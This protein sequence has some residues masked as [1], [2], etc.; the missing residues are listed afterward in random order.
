MLVKLP[1]PKTIPQQYLVA[2]ELEQYLGNPL[3]PDHEFSF[4]KIVEFDEQE[5]YPHQAHQ[6]LD[7][8]NLN[9]YH[10][11]VAYGGKLK[12]YEEFFALLRTVAR[13][14][15]TTAISYGNTFL[16]AVPIWVGGT[17]QQKNQ[18]AKIIKNRGKVSLAFH[19]K[20]HGSDFL[21]TDVQAIK[22]EDGYR[23]DGEK[24]LFGNAT[25]GS[26][27]TVFAKTDVNGG[28][29]GFSLF[30]LEKQA[31]DRSSYSYLSKCKTLGIRGADCSGIRFH[32]CL[33][34][35]ESLIS[36]QGS[37]L[38]LSLK[39]FQ[40][41]RTVI[42][43][44]ALGSADTALRTTISFALSRK[45]YGDS[46]FAI[47]HTQ[48]LLVDAFLDILICECVAIATSRAVHAAT[49]QMRLWSAVVK[50]FVPTTIE[51]VIHNL[52][53]VMGA[54]YYLRE[55]HHGGIFQKIV[56][57][58]AVVSMFHAGTY[59]NLSTIGAALQFQPTV[60]IDAQRYAEIESSL[61]SIFALDQ[62][63]PAFEPER[64]ELFS[65]KRNDIL[66]GMVVA[67]NQLQSLQMKSE[68]NLEV[69]TTLLSQANTILSEISTQQTVFK[70]MKRR[71]GR[72]LE[73]SPELFE[74]A[75]KH[76]AVHTAAACLYMWLYNRKQLGEFFA[77]GEWL[78]LCLHKL[79]GLL[80]HS[81][82]PLPTSYRENVATELQKLYEQNQLFS[83]V[84]LK[85]APSKA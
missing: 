13:R 60:D 8:W 41:T 50:Y 78:V 65:R 63:L 46:I 67:I 47:P 34:P 68:V 39:A 56:R 30:L 49:A 15:L 64:L 31:L 72:D 14:D 16:G 4:Q 21:A 28:P 38:E 82:Q 3:D 55:G 52:S 1:S 85:L 54:R 51:K 17:E 76:C 25:V 74:L 45:L 12:S 18:V 42:P 71:Y 81:Q 61:E 24:W 73:K 7:E 66:Q 84:P 58:S 57:D 6:L 37:A 10:I 32:N 2:E 22:T 36:P 40:L 70:D 79:M 77:Q 75:E 35:S 26:A 80:H 23:L 62:E 27:V 59:L 83:I 44:L 5:A 48:K 11:P 43:A 19:E 29:R 33:I 20:A 9:H 53:I 69:I